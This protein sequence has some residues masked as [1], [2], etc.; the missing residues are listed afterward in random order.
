MCLTDRLCSR[1]NSSP[2]DASDD[3]EM[4]HVDLQSLTA[5]DSNAFARFRKLPVA[6]QLIIGI[7]GLLLLS[8]VV[9][10]AFWCFGSSQHDAGQKI[11]VEVKEQK[12]D[13][14]QK[15]PVEVKEQKS[16]DAHFVASLKFR[17]P[18]G[19]N[20]VSSGT[21][22]PEFDAVNYH[23]EIP[24]DRNYPLKTLV[25][26]DL[27]GG[28]FTDELKDDLDPVANHM[29]EKANDGSYLFMVM[30]GDVIHGN[31]YSGGQKGYDKV[32]K[33]EIMPRYHD[34]KSHL[35]RLPLFAVS[36]NSNNDSSFLVDQERKYDNL[37]TSELASLEIVR[38][39]TVLALWIFL[40]TEEINDNGL[41][42]HYVDDL[43]S[44]VNAQHYFVVSHNPLSTTSG[45]GGAFEYPA[46]SDIFKKH[47]DKVITYI[48][49]HIHMSRVFQT[50]TSDNRGLLNKVTASGANRMYRYTSSK[51]SRYI[52]PLFQACRA[53]EKESTKV[54]E[55][56]Y[57]MVEA[58]KTFTEFEYDL[59]DLTL[60]F[61][62]SQPNQRKL[63]EW[64]HFND[65]DG[66]TD[67][68]ITVHKDAKLL[69]DR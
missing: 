13:A 11:P 55:L 32:F 7:L 10:T 52:D 48:S 67:D 35:G 41:V 51:S 15:I 37:V 2:P 59:G 3:L 34:Q 49:G 1:K 63:F 31:A 43:L 28:Y 61:Y 65:P 8:V 38:D 22:D 26:A 14:G 69:G 12:T 5:D 64:R 19:R 21:F 66:D 56:E 30:A 25:V 16:D 9:W 17:G 33:N 46:L 42:G 29:N 18:D 57:G 62:E 24:L 40:S 53:P 27:A 60:R 47:S 54:P 6:Y 45:K 68:N 20:L 50:K 39:G 44:K 58:E 23:L 4:Q 36:G